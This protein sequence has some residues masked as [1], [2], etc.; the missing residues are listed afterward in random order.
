MQ[1]LVQ[2]SSTNIAR[3]CKINSS[4][5]ELDTY[6]SAAEDSGNSCQKTLDNVF[7]QLLG[8]HFNVKQIC[9]IDRIQKFILQL[10]QH[11]SM[12]L[13]KKRAECNSSL[14]HLCT[15]LRLSAH[16]IRL[17]NLKIQWCQQ[18]INTNM[19]FKYYYCEFDE[20]CVFQMEGTTKKC[21][22]VNHTYL[23]F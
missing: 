2:V 21:G 19:R 13:L 3:G 16:A 6:L 1:Y 11:L 15:V 7:A 22:Q 10:K 17:H 12:H 8:S 9:L 5:I 20:T 14:L 18:T 4:P 23:G